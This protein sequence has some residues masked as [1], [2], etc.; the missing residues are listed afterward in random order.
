MQ[1]EDKES[2]ETTEFYNHRFKN[3]ATMSILPATLFL[4]GVILFLV[5]AKR[6]VTVRTVGEL[7]P[8]QVPI[9]V[10][11]TESSR[12]VENYLDEGKYVHKGET[13]LVYH[14]ISNPAQAQILNDQIARYQQQSKDLATLKQGLTSNVNTFG[15]SEDKFGYAQILKD[16]LNQR[17]IFDLENQQ[18]NAEQS[19]TSSK[20]DRV[21]TLIAQSIQRVNANIAA[22]QAV[23][24]AIQNGGSYPASDRF[25]Y[26]Y[27]SYMSDSKGLSGDALIKVKN[28]YATQIQQQLDAQRDNLDTL[29]LQQANNSQ[30]NTSG[31]RDQE[32]AN[33]IDSLQSTQLKNAA[34]LQNQNAVDLDT[35][36]AKLKVLNDQA[37]DYTVKAPVN[38]TL[39]VD[40]NLK[41][42]NYISGGNVL[43]DIYPVITKQTTI[44]IT[45]PVAANDIL[46]VKKGQNI[47]LRIARNVPTP[48]IL[49]GRVVK[50]DVAPTVTKNGNV[51][52][53]TAQSKISDRTALS[54]RYG[55][56][57]DASIIT[58]Q[59]TYWNYIVDR[60]FNRA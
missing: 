29:Q 24:T 30:T 21:G 33:K 59:K 7:V 55:L 42:K 60:L 53:V 25:G 15:K 36:K 39:H 19:G 17:Q 1:L 44:N 57:G 34:D 8:T 16:Y 28:S 58:G 14:D 48:L 22:Y 45:V 20:V 2:L 51:F 40:S 49:D 12:I 35:A 38:G 3:F 41:G 27:S 31:L 47:R 18:S 10:Q 52:M 23:L 37:K 6:E 26:L 4:I 5:F 43:A 54:L 9:S 46:A 56:N 32:T 50:I 13:L 11:A